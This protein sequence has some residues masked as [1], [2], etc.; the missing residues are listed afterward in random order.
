MIHKTLLIFFIPALIV[1]YEA[2]HA[3]PVIQPNDTL[4]R[5]SFHSSIE[6]EGFANYLSGGKPD[7]IAMAVAV[8]PKSGVQEINKVKEVIRT[9]SA[10]LKNNISGIKKSGK[11]LVFIFTHVQTTLLKEYDLDADFADMFTSGKYNCLTATLLYS[12]LF[13][14]LSYKYTIKFMP[15]HVY[16]MVYDGDVPYLFETTDPINGCIELTDEKQREA[17]QNGMLLHYTNADKE[18]NNKAAEIFDQYFIKLNNTGIK[19]LVGY[20]YLNATYSAFSE[21]KFLDAFKMV[22]KANVLTPMDGLKELQGEFLKLSILTEDKTSTLRASLLVAYYNSTDDK[23]RKNQIVDE[24]Y[25]STREI[26]FSHFPSPDSLLPVYK[27]IY[28]G[29]TDDDVRKVIDEIY[30]TQYIAY[31]ESKDKS[32]EAFD[33]ACKWYAGGK[34]KDV[35]KYFIQDHI[36]SFAIDAYNSRDAVRSYDS[37]AGLYPV[38]MEFELFRNK[39]C[40]VIIQAAQQAFRAKNAYEG[41]RLLE[42]FDKGGY[43]TEATRYCCNPAPVYSQAGSYYFKTGNSVKAKAALKKGLTFDPEN[44]EIKEK[45]KA[46]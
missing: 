12:L 23:N 45:L 33:T 18:K 14:D 21:Q 42:L 30:F 7:Y 24:F 34:S 26:L 19:G 43:Y 27:T 9:E 13:E 25:Q 44:Q 32:N 2:V 16:P 3:D 10:F 35:A 41:E 28:T 40:Q 6:K 4:S 15:G 1:Y 39:R 5:L 46:L 11:R 17:I 36:N 22:A 38:L 8:N 31:L 37:V 29:I 20:Q